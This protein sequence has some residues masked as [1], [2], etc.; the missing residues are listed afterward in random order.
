M[1]KLRAWWADAQAWLDTASSNH[2]WLLRGNETTSQ[3]VKRFDTREAVLESARP[4][5][6]LEFTPPGTPARATSWGRI[7]ASYR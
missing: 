1:E 5:L 2:G 7:R 3:S 6:T 4:K